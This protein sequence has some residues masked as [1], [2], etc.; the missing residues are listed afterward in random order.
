ML[1]FLAVPTNNEQ[2]QQ[3]NKIKQPSSTDS[4]H[5]IFLYAMFISALEQSVSFDYHVDIIAMEDH[6]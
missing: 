3:H 4:Y 2:Q 5:S 1:M 6:S